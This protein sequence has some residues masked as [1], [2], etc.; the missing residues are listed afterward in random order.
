MSAIRF[1]VW[2]PNTHGGDSPHRMGADITREDG[3][4]CVSLHT[5][6]ESE[7]TLD[8]AFRTIWTV[9]RRDAAESMRELAREVWISLNKSGSSFAQC[10]EAEVLP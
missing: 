4:D 7:N 5:D 9:S 8:L 2:L 1:T 10:D 3:E 6:E